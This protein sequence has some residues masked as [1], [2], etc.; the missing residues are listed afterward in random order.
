MGHI[1]TTGDSKGNPVNLRLVPLGLKIDKEVTADSISN[2]SLAWQMER[3]A[4][5]FM[6]TAI[7]CLRSKKGVKISTEQLCNHIA[8]AFVQCSILIEIHGEKFMQ[9]FIEKVLVEI[10]GKNQSFKQMKNKNSKKVG[11]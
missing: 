8:K 9:P 5:T 6:E 2:N 7:A 1:K 11:F 10:Q 4:E 3:A